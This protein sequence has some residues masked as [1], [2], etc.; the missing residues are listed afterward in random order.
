MSLE[1][2]FQQIIQSEQTAENRKES[3]VRIKKQISD[4]QSDLKSLKES[5]VSSKGR[6]HVFI[7]QYH[8]ED[9]E[10]RVLL[11]Q[12]KV[13]Q[14]RKIEIVKEIDQLKFVVAEK[15][16]IL[17][18]LKSDFSKN[19]FEFCA[20]YDLTG[21]GAQKRKEEKSSELEKIESEIKLAE[22]R[23]QELKLEEEEATEL[24]EQKACFQAEISQ[25]QS[26]IIEVDSS[27]EKKRQETLNT[28]EKVNK[29]RSENH[30][31]PELIQLQKELDSIKNQ[32]LEGKIR[33]LKAELNRV[34]R[35]QWQD[36]LR[37]QG[38]Y[39]NN[40]PSAGGYKFRT[41]NHE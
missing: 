16:N 32:E 41:V 11:E 27:L 38:S 6:L 19:V 2:L 12:K 25:L 36:S 10:C 9:A 18:K 17:E 34:K 21:L 24:M 13:L 23:L 28:I 29:F 37:N 26:E 30:N 1:R 20:Q 5:C 15:E 35:R 31:D 3:I 22:T 39:Q 40:R 8:E 4:C 14:E 7:R 33:N